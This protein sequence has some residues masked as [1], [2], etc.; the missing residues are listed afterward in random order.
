MHGNGT[1]RPRRF[2]KQAAAAVR[3]GAV[4]VL[5]D[6]RPVRTPAGAVLRLPTEAF[7]ELIAEEWRAQTDVIDL[8]AM[9]ILRFAFTA[10]DRTAPARQAVAGEIA[11]FA[12]A[13]VLCH[14]ASGPRSL[15]ER[16]EA[17]WTPWLDWS[18]TT[19][20]APL[21][22]SEGILPLVQPEA[23]LK[24]LGALALE[25]DDFGLTLTAYAAGL[26]G[27]GVLAFAVRRRA[28]RAPEAFEISRLD[29]A[30]QEERWGED[31]EAAART[32]GLR[33]DAIVLEGALSAL[34]PTLRIPE[35]LQATV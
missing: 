25:D 17:L 16:Q 15:A 4:E 30:H 12:G 2:Y 24:R 34:E 28:L 8:T 23:S 33:R 3:E 19:L 1:T 27:S 21:L 14:R 13:D 31:A 18:A 5:L 6:G 11:R 9:P 32:D 35:D 29:E 20:Q 26:F 22:R 10:L 7:G